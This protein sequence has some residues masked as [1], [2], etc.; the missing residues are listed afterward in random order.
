M[1]RVITLLLC[2]FLFA[3]PAHA[4]NAAESVDTTAIVTENGACQVNIDVQIRLDEP[5]RGLKFPLGTDINSVTLNGS[6]AS[7][8]QSGGITSVDLTHLDGKTG[9]YFCSISYKVNSV[10]ETDDEGRRTVNV[11][12]LYGFPYP[13]ESMSFSATMPSEFETVPAF[14]SGYHGQDIERQMTA[15]VNGN[16]IR[17]NLQEPLKD[18]ETLFLKLSAPDGMFPAVRTFGGSLPFDAAAMGIFAALSVVYWIF[19]MGCLPRLSPRRATVPEGISAGQLRSWLV[20]Q[21]SDLAG[22]VL[23]WAQL[24]YLIIHQDEHGRVFLHKKM[25]MGNERNSFELRCFRDLFGRKQS[26]EATGYRF[27]R[28]CESTAL[29]SRRHACGYR[30]PTG[31]IRLFRLLSCLLGLFAGMAM[32]DNIATSHTWRIVIMALLGMAG[33]LLCWLIQDGMGNLH[34]RSKAPVKLSAAACALF[35]LA[36]WLCRCPL[37]SLGAVVWNLLAGLMAS[38]GGKRTENGWRIYTEILGL[39]RHMRKAGRL[40]LRRILASNRNYYYELAPYALLLGVDKIF[41][42]K[43]GDARLPECTWLV[44]GIDSR[45]APVWHSQLREVYLTMIQDRKPTLAER[46]FGK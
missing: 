10:V 17:G 4:S 35:L 24:G 30:F 21:P 11:P 20:H 29:K 36:G 9:V 15:S 19:T 23:Q 18:S 14:F 40:E 45:T 31:S 13:V 34:L 3:V 22:M 44:T 37:Y 1:R 43:F 33:T 46:I 39:R 2:I 5:A 12:L 8:S 28:V 27:Q 42:Q 41:A 16:V 32:G 26:V 6:S 25:D 7:L 38:Y